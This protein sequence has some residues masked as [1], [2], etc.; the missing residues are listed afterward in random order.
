[1]SRK[2]RMAKKLPETVSA[3]PEHS[4][5]EVKAE[6]NPF[7]DGDWR[8][9]GYAWSG[10]A[11]RILLVVG[12][13]FSAIQFLQAREERRVERAL[14]LVDLWERPEY[15]SAQRALKER[16]ADLNAQNA[17]LLGPTPTP[18]ELAV[19]YRR[20]GIA[21]MGGNGAPPPDADFRDQFDR[22]LYFLNRMAFCVDGNLCSADVVDAYFGDF[23]RS[24]WSYFAGH[25]EAERQRGA[26]TLAQ[27]LEDYLAGR[28]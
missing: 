19:Y 10:F 13:V 11:L 23:A 1:M 21:V 18:Q 17:A 3:L 26:P 8:M 5:Q 9:I 16:L 28:K 6:P 25:V 15:Q 27:P 12:A 14:Q 24:F 4:P 20:I 2:I 22:I 7:S